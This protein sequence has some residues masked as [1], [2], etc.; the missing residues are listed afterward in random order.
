MAK[1][2]D[3]KVRVGFAFPAGAVPLWV[4]SMLIPADSPNVGGALRFINFMTR[5]E[6][7][8]E[9]TQ[10]TRLPPPATGRQR[11]AA[12]DPAIRDMWR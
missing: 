5:P 4:D 2:G 1:E 11:N 12:V 3:T 6:I 10:P 9:V 7:S 8:A